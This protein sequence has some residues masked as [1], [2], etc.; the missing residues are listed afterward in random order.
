MSFTESVKSGFDNYVNFDGRA[1]R[2]AFWFWILFQV[3]VLVGLYIVGV[4][5]FDSAILYL[6]GALALFLPSLAV[7]IRRLHDTD[8]SGWWYLISLIPFGGI[9]LIVFLAQKSDPVDNQYGPPPADQGGA[10][11]ASPPPAPAA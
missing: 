9:V 3:I 10:A 6:L 2:S 5:L 8:R 7:A 11:A 4:A 1:S